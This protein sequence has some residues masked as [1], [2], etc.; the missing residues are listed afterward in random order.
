MI[1]HKV[2]FSSFRNLQDSNAALSPRFTFIVGKNAQGKTSFLEVISLLCELASFRKANLKD[3]IT[4]GQSEASIF[5][6]AEASGLDYQTRLILAKGSRRLKVNDKSVIRHKDYLG[7]LPLVTFTPDDVR[8]SQGS[9]QRRRQF[10]DR[11]LFLFDPSHWDRCSEYNKHLKRRNILL[12]EQ[13]IRDPLFEVYTE[14]LASLGAEISMCR[15]LMSLKIETEMIKAVDA[16][17]SSKDNISMRY[18]TDFSDCELT[19]ENIKS[20]TE[21]LLEKFSSAVLRDKRVGYTTVGP[22]VEDLAIYIND[23]KASDFASQGQHRTI[24]LALK[25]SETEVVHTV[26]GIFPVLLIDDLSSELDNERREK[27]FAYLKSTGGQVVLTST[28]ENIA[29]GFLDEECLIYKV[30]DGKLE[31][32]N[33]NG[34]TAT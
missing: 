30:T 10:L 16:V 12:K 25:I 27:L 3:L 17:S 1:I 31:L 20:N 6:S 32:L 34:F 13:K 23:K 28:D 26:R 19:E 21:S 4:F 18:N 7:K 33:N 15:Q 5:C 9:P 29:T 22:H 14:K 11:A 24:A 2:E 8:L